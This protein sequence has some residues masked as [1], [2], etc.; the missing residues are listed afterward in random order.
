MRIIF[1]GTPGFA[2][3]SLD[4]LIANDFDIVGVITAPDRKAGRGQKLRA[5]EVKQYAEEKGLNILQPTNL[6]SPAFQGELRSL[7]ADLQVVVAF[8][9]LPESVWNMPPLGTINLHASLLPQYRGAAPINWVL[10][11]GETQ[12]GVTTFFI[13]HQIDTGDLLMQRSLDIGSD[14]TAGELH[15]RLMVSG[16]ELVLQTTRGIADNSLQPIPQKIDQELK[17]SPKIFKEDCVI[18]WTRSAGDI[19]NLIRGL[20]PYPVATTQLAGKVLKI[21]RAELTIQPHSKPAGF[22]E[23]KGAHLRYYAPYGFLELKEIQMEG[24]KRMKVEDF[25]R[26]YKID[27]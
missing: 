14:E 24:K 3:A 19:F 4:I 12:T 5:S 15:D 20:S 27:N 7:R 6:K 1:M 26:G 22:A 21:Y 23:V 18:D 2:V 9:M 10:I 16:A 25:L 11:N 8:R 13:E 17:K